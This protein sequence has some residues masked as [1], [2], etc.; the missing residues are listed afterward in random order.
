MPWKVPPR[1]V[2]VLALVLSVCLPAPA[3]SRPALEVAGPCGARS[4]TVAQLRKLPVTE[5]FG[6]VK[7]STGK[8]TL[9]GRYK[10]VALRDLLAAIGGYDASKNVT[11]AARDGYSITFSHEQV[12]NGAFTA[13]DP[14]TGD[15][16]A[17]H[18]PLHAI[19]VYEHDGRPLDFAED[20]PLRVMVVSERGGQ[21]TD[22][23]WSIKWATKLAIK[24]A[25]EAWSL[26]LQ[27]ARSEVMDRATFESGASP[28]CHGVTW[29]DERGRAWT[30]IPLWLLVGRV[31]DALKHGARAFN[32]SLAAAG[33]TVDVI[34]G[35]GGAVSFGSA[36]LERNQGILIACLLD[37]TPLPG[38]SFP[39][40][41]A[42]PDLKD[43]ERAGGIAK[44]VV[45]ASAATHPR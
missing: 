29:Q 11:V 12:M 15:T 4:F 8:V 21:V 30:G 23:H 33:Y 25:S 17:A 36:R 19:L 14:G 28:K 38:K 5:G 27:G 6:G 35:D 3:T 10:G 16:L 41:L 42:G 24:P 40:Q 22:G 7:S 18:E 44:I 31:D 34:A 26:S 39:L 37:G 32:D 9:P 13:Y 43:E 2:P 45:R 20:G 1:V